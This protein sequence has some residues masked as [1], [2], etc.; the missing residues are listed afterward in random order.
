MLD[1]REKIRIKYQYLDPRDEIENEVKKLKNK[2][3]LALNLLKEGI[4]I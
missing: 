1:K 2:I 3:D 4:G